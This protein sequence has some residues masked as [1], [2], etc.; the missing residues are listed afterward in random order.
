MNIFVLDLDPKKCAADHCDKHLVKMC[1][2]HNQI[3]G[4]VAYY[5]RGVN[6]KKEI[7]QPFVDKHFVGFPRQLNGK[8]HPYGIGYRNHPCTIWA[9]ESI[10]NYEWLC[11]LNLEMCEEYTRRYKRTHAGEAITNWYRLHRPWLP[12]VG[13]TPFA[14]AMFDD[15]KHKDTV[16]AYRQYYKKYKSRIAKWAHSKEPSWW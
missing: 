9:G 13:M 5:A 12:S 10:Q 8:P 6:R 14:Q 3:L 16:T 1:T 7:T 2:E 4:S 11:T 15:V